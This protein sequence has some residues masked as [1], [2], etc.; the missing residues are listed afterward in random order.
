MSLHQFHDVL[1]LLENQRRAFVGGKAARKTDGQRVGIQQLVEADEIA[2]RDALALQQQPA[3][4]KFDQLAPQ[5][6]TQRPEFLVGNKSG[7]VIFSQNSGVI[8]G[9]QPNRAPNFSRNKSVSPLLPL[10]EF[11][12]PELPHR[13]FHPA[14]QMNAVGDVADGHLVFRHARIQRPATCGG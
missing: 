8:D 14:E 2:R 1:E 4:G 7:S 6:V 10:V 13:A 9:A 11:L 3:A 5:L 12:A